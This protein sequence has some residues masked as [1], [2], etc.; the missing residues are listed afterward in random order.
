M[1]RE[2]GWVKQRS[3]SDQGRGT[4]TQVYQCLHSCSQNQQ[5][6][7][8]HIIVLK[9]DQRAMRRFILVFSRFLRKKQSPAKQIIHNKNS[10]CLEQW[11]FP[12]FLC[13]P[14][15]KKK[16]YFPCF[17]FSNWTCVWWSIRAWEHTNTRE[18][19]YVCVFIYTHTY[20][21]PESFFTGY[22][23]NRYNEISYF[24]VCMLNICREWLAWAGRQ[25]CW[26]GL[27][28]QKETL[29]CALLESCRYDKIPATNSLTCN[30]YMIFAHLLIWVTATTEMFNWQ[31]RFN[32]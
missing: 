21:Y 31:R 14:R 19:I 2:L 18:Y 22:K 26:W 7:I 16:V 3:W 9:G 11:E 10:T 28:V 32:V 24:C 23:H 20:I 8:P 27:L 1:I 6:P 4:W 15:R 12:C 13:L 25:I 17:L 30:N 29:A 5:L